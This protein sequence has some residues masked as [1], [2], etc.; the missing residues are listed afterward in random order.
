MSE[1]LFL[2]LKYTSKTMELQ[3]MRAQINSRYHELERKQNIHLHHTQPR[4]AK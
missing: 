3:K 4:Q 1:N 2:H